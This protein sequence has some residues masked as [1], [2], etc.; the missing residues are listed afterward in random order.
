MRILIADNSPAVR[1][2][3]ICLLSRLD[4]MMVVAEA[5]NGW[6]AIRQFHFHRPDITLMDVSMPQ[7][8][9]VSATAAIVDEFPDARIILMSI[10]SDAEKSS[11]NAGA[12]GYLTKDMSRHLLL[13]TLRKI[14]NTN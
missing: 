3:L 11:L 2:G 5:E 9:G 7:M 10:F 8:D 6:E 12:K 1:E 4:D 14:H 13:D